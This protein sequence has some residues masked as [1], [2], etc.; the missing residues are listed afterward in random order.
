MIRFS[1]F[2]IAL[3]CILAVASQAFAITRVARSQNW[4]EAYAGGGT[5][6]GQ[7]NGL[8]GLAEGDFIINNALVDVD[9]GD[10]YDNSFHFG[11]AY[12]RTQGKHFSM[13]FGFRFTNHSL[14]D[15]IP[16]T[17]DTVLLVPD[18]LTLRQYDLELDVY[19]YP[20]DLNRSYVN[21][22]VG[23][24]VKGGITSADIKGFDSENDLTGGLC[25]N[26]GLEV[27][28]WRD[29]GR[30]SVALASVNS[31]DFLAS[32]DRP[33]YLNFGGALKYYFRM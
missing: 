4:I 14:Q 2:A 29:P 9:G 24:G 20:L 15:T 19:Y 31:W 6:T 18:D 3:L 5:P 26:F 23:L 25:L 22:Y 17:T 10:V 11:L 1:R 33:R 28:L 12:G 13:S 27:T 7:Y 16:L 30:A 8:P 32:G 21:P